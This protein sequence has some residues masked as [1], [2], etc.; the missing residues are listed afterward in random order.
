MAGLALGATPAGWGPPAGASEIRIPRRGSRPSVW[1]TATPLSS[2]VGSVAKITVLRPRSSQSAG[3]SWGVSGIQG[4]KY[5][6]NPP[7]RS[8]SSS[9]DRLVLGPRWILPM[10]FRSVN[11][12]DRRDLLCSGTIRRFRRSPTTCIDV[13]PPVAKTLILSNTGRNSSERDGLVLHFLRSSAG[14]SLGRM[15]RSLASVLAITQ[16]LCQFSHPHHQRWGCRL[17]P[18][19]ASF[20][21]SRHRCGP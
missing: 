12:Q 8:S 4:Q 21:S 9:Q 15:R 17:W 3:M 2:R 16:P 5:P 14:P 7:T 1:R 10:S 20:G 6:S 19:L 18:D 11:Q 13:R